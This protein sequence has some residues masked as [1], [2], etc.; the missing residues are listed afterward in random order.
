DSYTWISKPFRS[1]SEE[2]VHAIYH[3]KDGITWLGGPG[4]IYRYDSNVHKD[5]EREF[6][7]MVRKVILGE[8]SVLFGGA[9]FD[10]NQRV[11][12]DQPTRLTPVLAYEFNSLTFVYSAPDF[13]DESSIRYSHYL[14]GFDKD[15]HVWK[16]EA[17]ANYTNLPEG[18]YKFRVKAI[19]VNQHESVEGVYSFTIL[20][21]WHR[22][23]WAYIAYVLSFIG[24]VYAAI[25]VSTRGLQ[26]IIKEKTAD[27][28]AQKEEIEEKNKDITD[29]INYAQKIQEAILPS[30]EDIRA[31]LPESFVLFK[32]KDIV[33]GDFY[34]FSERDGKAILT[35]ADCTGHGVPGAFMSMI[36]NSLLNEI[37][38]EQGV[39]QPAQI[40]QLLKMAVIKSLKQTGEA[41]TQK[42]GMDIAMVA[43]DTEKMKLEFA[44]AYNPLFR[45]RNGELEETRAD[46][47]PIGIYSDDGGKVFTNYPMDMEKG[48][49]YFFFTDGFVD[50]FGG[51]KGKKFMNKRFKS[52]LMDIH[53]QPM[54]EQKT[55]LDEVIEDWKANIDGYGNHYEQMD[56]ILIIG[57]R[58]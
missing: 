21:P 2:I 6:P 19:N 12:L 49:M 27:I 11:T 43:F 47:M 32:P 38:N 53:L 39:T 41:G 1:V 36:G 26:Q 17:K 30:D 28:V 20:P 10:E 25:T 8:D 40:I 57:V 56:D 13:D 58:V 42:D 55:K 31:H 35:A 22:T 50:Q 4:G 3:D 34:W 9:Y 16:E 44:G 46:R 24:F 45:I 33:S 29:S 15:W 23:V 14:E 5:Y 51:P 52:L 7:A 54:E 48:D 37:V 18:K